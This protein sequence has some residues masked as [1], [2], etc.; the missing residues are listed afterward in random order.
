MSTAP[1]E[2]VVGADVAT[3][4]FEIEVEFKRWSPPPPATPES[5]RALARRKIA[6]LVPFV[7]SLLGS[8]YV[9]AAI[10]F[11]AGLVLGVLLTL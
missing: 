6:R 5:I 1:P 7:E 8:E 9:A 4:R 10:T 11:V 2:I 3:N